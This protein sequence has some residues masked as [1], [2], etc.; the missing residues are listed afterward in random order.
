MTTTY[1]TFSLPLARSYNVVFQKVGKKKPSFEDYPEMASYMHL[2]EDDWDFFKRALD[3]RT[4]INDPEFDALV[5][6]LLIKGIIYLEEEEISQL[7]FEDMLFVR[8]AANWGN[9][10]SILLHMSN[11]NAHRYFD[12]MET[13]VYPAQ[14]HSEYKQLVKRADSVSVPALMKYMPEFSEFEEA[15]SLGESDNILQFLARAAMLKPKIGDV[16]YDALVSKLKNKLFPSIV[17][18]IEEKKEIFNPLSLSYEEWN[19]L[20]QTYCSLPYSYPSNTILTT[21][22]PSKAASFLFLNEAAKAENSQSESF[23][24]LRVSLMGRKDR[25]KTLVESYKNNG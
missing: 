20:Y 4:D 25:T 22:M 1:Y 3:V 6:S 18:S 23:E 19:A 9:A 8:H 16:G 24:F 14:L 10:K 7:S 12:E 11:E 5:R 2:T 15:N 13:H 21:I 17:S